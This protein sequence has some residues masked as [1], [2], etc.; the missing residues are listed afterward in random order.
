VAGKKVRDIEGEGAI[1]PT[2]GSFRRACRL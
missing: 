1:E 2:T